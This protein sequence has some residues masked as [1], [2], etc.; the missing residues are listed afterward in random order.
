MNRRELI[1]SGLGVMAAIGLGAC[2]VPFTADPTV[3]ESLPGYGIPAPT[4]YLRSN[5]SRDPFSLC[6][7][8]YLAPDPLGIEAR[9]K[10]ARPVA[11]RL[12]FA[13]EA[14]SIDSPAM[15]HGAVE[16]GLRAASEVVG[17]AGPGSKVVVIGAGAAGLACSRDLIDAGFEITVLEGRD[18]L[19]GRV[20][21][22]WLDGTPVEMGAAWIHGVAGNPLAELARNQ[23]VETIPFEYEFGFPVF[24]QEREA[25]EGVRQLRRGLASFDWGRR[26]PATTTVA[27]L[28]PRRRSIGLQW[29]CVS[30][31]AQEY[32]VDPERLAFLATDE[33]DY[34]RGGDALIKGS[35]SDL[36]I[37]G[38]G[39]IPVR[40][41]ST[42][43]SIS[44]GD[45]SDVVTELAG[46]E[47][48]TSDAVVV[49]VPIGV[50]KA[51]SIAF[52]PPLPS[53]NQA[54]IDALGAGLLDKLCLAFDEVFWDADAEMINWVDP[55]RPGLW[56]AWVNGH[57]LFGVPLL[58]GYNGGGQA[59]RM[60]G[61]DDEAVVRS[62]M[63]ALDAMFG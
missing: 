59:E 43:S 36:V 51:G 47:T 14:T 62:G 13:G 56:A 52:D 5:W 30:E 38:A 25:I 48:F 23:G 20:R 9:R 37:E 15:V 27:D 26:N 39:E 60:A 40:T 46:G 12:F 21:T 11:D 35:Y 22:E 57:R 41:E 16:S 28:L 17:V 10:L 24:G 3:L 45:G 32:G 55:E 54:G 58:L 63:A 29:A 6:S 53:P 8:S 34:L 33:G 49:T 4:A 7:Y 50:L 19:G 2:R 44:Y 31:I 18:R 61:L 1:G 42:V